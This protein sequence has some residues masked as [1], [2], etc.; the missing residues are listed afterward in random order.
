MPHAVFLHSALTQHR[1]VAR[2][3]DHLRRLFRFEC[4]DVAIALGVAG[5]VN[6]A[7]LVMAASTFF[8]R[9]LTDVGTIEE[10][11]RTLTPLLGAAS[12]WVF[13]V[14]LL[15]SGLSS[16]AVGTMA[17]QVIM[18]GFLHRRIPLWLRRL[19]TMLPALVVIAIGL[20]PTRTLVLS[21]VVLSFGLPF[22]LLP[23]VWFTARRD[24]MG[25]LVNRRGTTV[26][27]AAV[28]ALVVTLNGLL[29]GQVLFGWGG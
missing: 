29:L 6:G 21:Q 25:L 18:Q 10:A 20:E 28:T 12:S 17:G 26:L 7:M 22:A 16:S 24:L 1:I 2:T 5:L 8:A 15:A 19:V 3:P 11:H 13:A 9:G 23:L 27:A 4:V 14:S